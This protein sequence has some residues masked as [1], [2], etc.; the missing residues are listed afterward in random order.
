MSAIR[1]WVTGSRLS[2]SYM[3]GW[4]L[5]HMKLSMWQALNVALAVS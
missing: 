3:A 5:P 4:P 1:S 2:C